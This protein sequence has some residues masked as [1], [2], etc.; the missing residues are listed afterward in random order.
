MER[1][2]SAGHLVWKHRLIANSLARLVGCITWKESTFLVSKMKTLLQVN[3]C[4]VSARFLRN[5][6]LLMWN[7]QLPVKLDCVI[8]IQKGYG[9]ILRDT[10]SLPVGS[11]WL[12]SLVEPAQHTG[13]TWW[14]YWAKDTLQACPLSILEQLQELHNVQWMAAVKSC[15]IMRTG[16]GGGAALGSVDWKN[17]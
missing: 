3:I 7:T 5:T 13:G 2:L 10:A 8:I 12:G 4:S 6:D 16:G 15:Y 9:Y 1:D 14:K 17:K 11:R